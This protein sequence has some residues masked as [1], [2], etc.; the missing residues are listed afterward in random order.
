M[1]FFIT[2]RGITLLLAI[3][4][5][6]FV[7]T[8]CGGGDPE[9]ACPPVTVK[10]YGDSIGGRFAK[11]LQQVVDVERGPGRILVENRAVG[12][13]SSEQMRTGTDGLNPPWPQDAAADVIFVVFGQYDRTISVHPDVYRRNLEL[14]ASFGARVL[15]PIPV[16]WRS[17]EWSP[18]VK[19]AHSVPGMIDIN[20]W[21]RALGP[22]WYAHLPDG[23]HP[24]PMI[25]RAVARALLIPAIPMCGSGR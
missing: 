20:S 13:T 10:V 9:P 19:I 3:F 5:C 25:S 17:D 4:C 16:D 22:A 14:F 23:T 2:S 11:G 8:A 15:T 18:Y 6:F 7:L 24:D 12:A 1:K 21:A